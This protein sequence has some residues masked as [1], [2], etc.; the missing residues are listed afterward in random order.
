MN[1][2]LGRNR[3]W[4]GT[5][6]DD[7]FMPNCCDSMDDVELAGFCGEVVEDAGGEGAINIVSEAVHGEE[8]GEW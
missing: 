1:C 7:P 4:N 6:W 5:E 3:R 2:S 8:G